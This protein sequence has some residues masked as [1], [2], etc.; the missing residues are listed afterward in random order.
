MRESIEL[1]LEAIISNIETEAETTDAAGLRELSEALVLAA[2]VA[3]GLQREDALKQLQK[4]REV[5]A[6]TQLSPKVS[7]LA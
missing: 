6:I 2:G 4:A 1:A 5:Q 7:G 3:S